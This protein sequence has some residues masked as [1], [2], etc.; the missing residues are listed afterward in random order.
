MRRPIS[1]I[2]LGSMLI[3]GT[4]MVVTGFA[5][6]TLAENAAET[7]AAGEMVA[8]SAAEAGTDALQEP[9]TSEYESSEYETADPET[10][11]PVTEP[12]TSEPMTEP[13]TLFA[14]E[15]ADYEYL[16]VGSTT[17][18][19]GKFFTD[20]WGNAMSDIDV[21]A[22]I[23]GYNLVEWK[24]SE[25]TFAIDPSV[26][27][28]ITVVEDNQTGN[29]TYYFTVYDDLFYNDGTRITARDYAFSMLL[30]IA[31][32]IA[33]LGGNTRDLEYVLGY[34]EYI[35]GEVPY[36][37]GIR[38]L[39]D[40]L[41]SITIKG[42]YLPF[43]Y[44]LGL[45]DCVPYPI[46]VIAPGCQVEDLGNG[47][48]ITNIPDY[49]EPEEETEEE[50]SEE[51]SPENEEA[52]SGEDAGEFTE[53]LTGEEASEE[54]GSEAETEEETTG[55]GEE[56]PRFTAELLTKTIMDE[57]SGYLAHPTVTSGPYT[58]VSFD[59]STAYLEANEYYK[60]NSD[61]LRPVIDRLEFATA[62]NATM[63]DE[64]EAGEYGLLNK[65]MN[66]DAVNAG[67]A[68]TR[69]RDRHNRPI[70]GMSNYMRTGLAMISFSTERDMVSSEKMRQAISHCIDKQALME[71][72]VG[73]S[74]G[75][76]VNGYYGIGQWMYQLIS[77]T[78]AMPYPIDEPEDENDAEAVAAY[79]KE[80]AEWEALNLDNVEIYELDVNQAALLF[81]EEGWKLN[82]EGEAF[83]P[84]EDT[85]RYRAEYHPEWVE[86]EEST[87]GLTETEEFSGL[88]EDGD[89]TDAA[90]EPAG[91]ETPGAETETETAAEPETEEE[92]AEEPVETEI[93]EQED[94][95]FLV[96]LTLS[97]LIPEGNK[98]IDVMDENFTDYLAEAGAVLTISTAPM[99][100]VLRYYYRQDN[101]DFDM[102]Y[103]ATNFDVVFDPAQTFLYTEPEEE[104]TE[105]ETEELTTEEETTEIGLEEIVTGEEELS[106]EY[107]A[108]AYE[109]LV[110]ESTISAEEGRSEEL[111][112]EEETTEE[113]PVPDTRNTTGISD[114][115]LYELAVDMRRTDPGDVLTYMKKWVAFQERF[116]EV[117]PLIPIYSNVYFDFYPRILHGYNIYENIS[118][119]NAIVGAWLSDPEDEEETTE[120]A[121]AEYEAADGETLEEID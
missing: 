65:V 92:T 8:E 77:H 78:G 37:S 96:P 3:A 113:L 30:S 76:V 28:G 109:D 49:E 29:R 19:G 88:S 62:D 116:S 100:E 89:V 106:G 15:N 42:E 55:S 24:G 90:E 34:E 56:E 63:V 2:A 86:E 25:G 10:P 68:L 12:E 45:L 105:A 61:G 32:Q 5:G 58:L 83:D 103:M 39:A 57:E 110:E 108:A 87:E 99:D 36:L 114:K 74:M 33:E 14:W 101:R 27:S 52:V 16:R 81:E 6:K 85:V 40:N 98:I 48:M 120:E 111:T 23:H 72:Y 59:G 13:E 95:W 18:F 97:L 115:T 7:S 67:M 64:L 1:H 66:G 69:L 82:A 47:V 107:N 4:A 104:T 50:L 94:G 91:E 121:E 44:E 17:P 21:R 11:E 9:L 118:W 43:F 119:G 75:S 26:V 80:L 20:M 73:R 117:V 51:E 71:D 35:N 54:A 102:I 53:E 46:H 112:A 60:G 41:L 79:E 84:E 93:V 38:V 22:L 31:P 70:Y